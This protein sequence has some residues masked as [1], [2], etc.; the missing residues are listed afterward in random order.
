M[1]S[2]TIVQVQQAICSFFVNL[3]N[4]HPIIVILTLIH[5]FTSNVSVNFFIDYITVPGLDVVFVMDSSSDVTASN[6]LKQKEAVKSM[7]RSVN[8]PSGKSRASVIT[9]GSRASLVITFNG[10]SNFSALES[11]ID[12][13]PK[14]D[15]RRRIDSALVH[16]GKVLS[17]ARP[18]SRKMVVLFT[19]GRTD[20]SS[21]DLYT[22][23][24]QIFAQDAEL[25]IFAIGER[26]YPPELAEVVSK[27]DHVLNVSSFANLQTESK[28][29]IR[30]VVRSLGKYRN[31]HICDWIQI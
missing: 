11:S 15:G 26:P 1:F 23:A 4:L 25:F 19:S 20:P 2:F 8:V 5:Q 10:Y 6:Y 22:S 3:P 9:F 7:A 18:L 16:A 13:A 21:R 31:L 14:I 30:S 27:P 24:R 29:A 17:E 12:L 28:E